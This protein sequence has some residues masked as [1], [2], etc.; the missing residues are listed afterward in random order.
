[1]HFF[2]CSIVLIYT[3]VIFSALLTSKLQ[4]VTWGHWIGKHY[5]D[6][7]DVWVWSDNA[8]PNFAYWAPGQP[9]GSVSFDNILILDWC[10][11]VPPHV[12]LDF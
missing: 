5:I 8:E 12:I 2:Q 4:S 1:M 7:E 6:R 10:W 11:Y 3:S 9:D